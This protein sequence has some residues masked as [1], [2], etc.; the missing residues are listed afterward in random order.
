M[1]NPEMLF[2]TIPLRKYKS[3]CQCNKKLTSFWGFRTRPSTRGCSL[4]LAGGHSPY[5]SGISPT[6]HST[7]VV[8][9]AVFIALYLY[10]T[11]TIYSSIRLSSRKCVITSVFTVVCSASRKTVNWTSSNLVDDVVVVESNDS[12]TAIPSVNHSH[13][14]SLQKLITNLQSY[15]PIFLFTLQSEIEIYWNNTSTNVVYIIRG[16][17]SVS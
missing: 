7:I 4:D 3:I 5:I 15:R 12:K 1:F 6:A 9:I 2:S 17:R 13:V 10:C 16:R 11:F 14:H 8:V